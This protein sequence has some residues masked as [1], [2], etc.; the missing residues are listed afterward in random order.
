MS[1]AS[2]YCLTWGGA[3]VLAVILPHQASAVWPTD[4]TVNV[5][6][7]TAVGSQQLP[8]AMLS[9]GRAIASDGR[10]GA[11]VAW[12]DFRDDEGRYAIYAQRVDSSGSVQW[13]T[14]GV[15]LRRICDQ[16][17]SSSWNPSITTDDADG[18]IVAWIDARGDDYPLMGIYAQRVSSAG[19]VLWGD[20]NG[21]AICKNVDSGSAPTIV[22]DGE[23]GAIVAWYSGYSGN[24]PA[25]Y[26]SY[27]IYAQRISA[28]GI[29]EWAAGGI[30]LCTDDTRAGGGMF[31]SPAIVSDGAGGAIVASMVFLNSANAYGIFALRVSA[32]GTIL[33]GGADSVACCNSGDVVGGP[34]IASDGA[35]GAIVAWE[36]HRAGSK[37]IY[38]QRISSGGTAQWV[39]NGVALCTALHNQSNPIAVPNGAG[40]AIVTWTDGRNFMTGPYVYAQKV[41]ATGVAQWTS[42]GVVVC[43]SPNYQNEPTIVGDGAGGAIFTWWDGD[44]YAQRI[45]SEGTAQ[46]TTCGVVVCGAP[47]GQYAPTIVSAG[48]GGAIVAWTDERTGA[49][50]AD[51]YAQYVRPDGTLGGGVVPVRVSLANADVT[52]DDV[53]L[54]WYMDG[55][56]GAATTVLRCLGGNEWARIGEVVADGTGYLR[57]TDPVNTTVP[58]VGYRLGIVEE[59]IERFYG[60]VW[61]DLPTRDVGFALDPVHPNPSCGRSLTVR[62]TLAGAAPATIELLDVAG[63]R[64]AFR[65]VASLGAGHHALDLRQGAHLSPGL[66]I[67]RLTQ[68]ADV[69]TARVAVIQ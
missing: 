47:N 61:V 26:G 54:T 30:A 56:E 63:R 42:N 55:G 48:D 1:K 7:C 69:R 62:F 28:D 34:T 40:G 22:S 17:G 57:F 60:E 50:N 5:P 32:D 9:A 2:A 39:K 65:D 35:H 27:N 59:G 41:S 16:D 25:P 11:I 38:A 6:L 18:A 31:Y 58:R 43:A 19:T 13:T 29:V 45:S 52:A 3:L 10:H 12:N 67:V 21:V 14:D 37:D 51:I 68:G 23:G 53:K 64:I 8:T 15:A 33:W 46:W 4:P 44:V 66:Y 36:D 49:G 20:T 24:M